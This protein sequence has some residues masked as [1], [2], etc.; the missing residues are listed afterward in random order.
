MEPQIRSLR[1]GHPDDAALLGPASA[2]VVESFPEFYRLFAVPE[3][4]LLAVIDG[5]L[6]EPASELGATRV[7]VSQDGVGGFYAA[8]PVREM[9]QRQR[10]DLKAL[11]S[12]DG[13]PPSVW[14]RVEA[15]KKGVE[16][17]GGEAFY[18]ARIAVSSSQ[19]CKGL[20]SRL[21][22][23]FEAEARSRGFRT[24]AMH[25]KADNAPALGLYRARGYRARSSEPWAYPVLAKELD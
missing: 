10:V 11:I 18:L 9:A 23:D 12:L 25:V 14:D 2:L 19:R 1:P 6:R 7:L 5:Q 22:D 24:A 21:L 20:G 17:P 16:A 3:E 13:L 15:F 8:Y 4:R